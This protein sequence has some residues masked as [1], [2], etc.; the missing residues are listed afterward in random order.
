MTIFRAGFG[1][2]GR[3]AES[4]MSAVSDPAEVGRIFS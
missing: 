3:S 1:L 4:I 2:T